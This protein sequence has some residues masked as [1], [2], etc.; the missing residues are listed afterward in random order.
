MCRA[1]ACIYFPTWHLFVE[2]D[3]PW[4]RSLAFRA[5]TRGTQVREVR[6]YVGYAGTRACPFNLH[7][8]TTEQR[9]RSH[10]FSRMTSFF[11]INAW[12]TGHFFPHDIYFARIY[13]PAWHLLLKQMNRGP[14]PL[15][16]TLI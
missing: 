1:C 8:L 11:E 3:E 12:W 7:G 6:G 5:G 10:L 15:S 4:L 16:L 9:V 13:F 2:I 14:Q